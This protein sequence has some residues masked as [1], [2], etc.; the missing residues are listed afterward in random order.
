MSDYLYPPPAPPM[1]D[2]ALCRQLSLMCDLCG[3]LVEKNDYL[4]NGDIIACEACLYN[5]RER[6]VTV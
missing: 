5:A 6:A 3:A 4:S 1:P 2:G